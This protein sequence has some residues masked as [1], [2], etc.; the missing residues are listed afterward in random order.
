MNLA[1]WIGSA[2]AVACAVWSLS[3]TGVSGAFVQGHG[4]AVVVGGTLA[5][6]FLSCPLHRLG[7]STVR[8]LALFLP[9]SMPAAEDVV[10]ELAR[11]ARKSQAEGGLLSLQQESL[12]FAGGFLHRAVL[13]AIATAETA[14][15]RRVLEE[16]IRQMRMAVQEDANV[17]RAVGVLAPMFGL[18]GTLLGMMN[19][20][21]NMSDPARVGPTMA[22]ALSSAFVGISI[23]T[24]VCIPM[25]GQIRAEAIR[26]TMVWELILEGVLGIASG[27]SPALIELQ[28]MGYLRRRRTA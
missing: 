22:M 2:L 15:T 10:S 16:E 1:V 24:I 4:L 9:S 28:L 6:A 25:A 19:V 23:A 18:L 11:L 7:S 20:V 27:K 8:L 14:E 13:L 21:E 17:F 5:G 26:N 3:Q 12:E